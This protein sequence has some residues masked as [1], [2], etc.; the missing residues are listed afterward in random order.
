[1]R[2][3]REL[4]NKLLTCLIVG[5]YVMYVFSC[6]TLKYFPK[7]HYEIYV[8]QNLIGNILVAGL[9]IWICHMFKYCMITK[10]LAYL[11]L[12]LPLGDFIYWHNMSTFNY[13]I[14]I[15]IY[16]VLIIISIVVIILLSIMD[17]TKCKNIY[18]KYNLFK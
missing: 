2:K 5:I 3:E 12:L 16:L 9:F 8:L 14:F 18:K 6:V 15:N 11:F 1:M 13:G 4:L 17:T 7:L 10:T